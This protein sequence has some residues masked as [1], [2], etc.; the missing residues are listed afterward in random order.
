MFTICHFHIPLQHNDNCVARIA[1]SQ[2]K[3]GFMEHNKINICL[4]CDNNY[5]KHAG[6]V[7]A[8]ILKNAA[9]ADILAF[10]ILDGGISDKNKT[11][12]ESLKSLR[13]CEIVFIS[14][15]NDLF[16][17]YLNVKTHAYLSIAA[18]YR[19]KLGSLLPYI[20]KIIYL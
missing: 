15:D 4:S 11:E 8:S 14:I 9:E 10:Y 13:K 16:I 5:A 1:K 20:D 6:V 19:L 2:K 3:L 18:Y 12:L 17:D 7:I